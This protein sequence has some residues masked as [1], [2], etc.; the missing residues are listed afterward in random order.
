M[1][2]V[3]NHRPAPFSLFPPERGDPLHQEPRAFRVGHPRAHG[4]HLPRAAHG[5]ARGKTL[6][7]KARYSDF[8]TFTRSRTVGQVIASRAEFS[9][10]A[11]SLLDQILPAEMGIRL[12]GL[13]LSSL[14]GEEGVQDIA[15]T[16]G[17]FAF[18]ALEN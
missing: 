7:L 12:L 6:V 15:T 17:S 1:S 3:E 14:V 8:R 9:Q 5:N 4:R 11:H 13:T 18:D 10:L 16:Q 2:L